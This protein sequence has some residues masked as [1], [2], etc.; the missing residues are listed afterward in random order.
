MLKRLACGSVALAV[1]VIG[2][3]LK[4]EPLSDPRH[5]EPNESG[6]VAMRRGDP[7]SR[8]NPFG[9]VRAS[10]RTLTTESSAFAPVAPDS[11]PY[12]EPVAFQREIPSESQSSQRTEMDTHERDP[13][14]IGQPFPV[15]VSVENSCKRDLAEM[16]EGATCG[17]VLRLL[18]D[19]AQEPRS[20]AWATSMEEKLRS[21]VLADPKEFTIRGIECRL[22]LCAIEVA[23]P[24]GPYLGEQSYKDSIASGISRS[25]GMHAYEIGPSSVRIT[26]T[27]LMFERR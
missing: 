19:M 3:T 4:R 10:D 23:S 12:S 21:M 26:V 17:K 11:T 1:V 22:S 7:D 25:I 24:N 15:S 13:D 8:P 20:P 9:E 5:F 27:L 2:V 6:Q 14:V 16:G 18:S